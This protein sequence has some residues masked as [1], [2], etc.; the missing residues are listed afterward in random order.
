M[1]TN[2]KTATVKAK[3]FEPGDEDGFT[4]NHMPFI[5]T[6]GNFPLEGHFYRKYICVGHK[7]ERWLVDR[8]LFE[9]RYKLIRYPWTFLKSLRISKE[10]ATFLDHLTH[11][12]QHHY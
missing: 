8:H 4:D 7:G 11:G 3:L 6:L 1:K 10:V 5:Y 2:T 9:V 12:H